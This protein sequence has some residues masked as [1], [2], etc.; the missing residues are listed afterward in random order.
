MEDVQ[1]VEGE[2]V[3]ATTGL[4]QGLSHVLPEQFHQFVSTHNSN[5]KKQKVS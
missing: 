2:E 3:I 4:P 5:N 1:V